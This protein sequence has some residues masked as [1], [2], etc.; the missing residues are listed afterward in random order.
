MAYGLRYKFAFESQSGVDYEIQILQDGYSGSVTQR[1]LGRA[2]VLRRDLNDCISG[3]SLEIA[4]EC[5]VDGEFAALYTSDAF[6]YKAVLYRS[7]S[8]I[9]TGFVSPELYSEP[10]IA[11]PYDVSITA[12]DGLGELRNVTFEGGGLK[13]LRAHLAALLAGTGLT[14]AIYLASGLTVTAPTAVAANDLL[15]RVSVDLDHMAGES[16]YD[17]LQALLASLHARI[18]QSRDKWLVYRDTDLEDDGGVTVYNSAGTALKYEVASFGS[19][20][21]HDWWP[22]GSM[23]SQVVPACKELSVMSEHDYVQVIPNGEITSDSDWTKVNATYIDDGYYRLTAG[24]VGQI[25]QTVVLTTATDESVSGTVT[26]TRVPLS[27][28]GKLGL[29]ILASAYGSGETEAQLYVSVQATFTNGTTAYLTRAGSGFFWSGTAGAWMDPFPI[30]L[31]Q[32]TYGEDVGTEV[33][34]DIP[35]YTE[36]RTNGTVASLQIT[37]G[38]GNTA[39]SYA[40]AIYAVVAETTPQSRGT[41]CKVVIDN[42]AR[43]EASETEVVLSPMV[44]NSRESL[45]RLRYGLPIVSGGPATTFATGKL[46]ASDYLSVIARDY[47]LSC[48]LPRLRTTG[49]LQV[50]AST[51]GIPVALKDSRGLLYFPDTVSWDL[52]L[53]EMTVDMTSLPAAQITVES[54]VMTSV[55]D[56]AS[57]SAFSPDYSG[58]GSG[59]SSAGA[60]EALESQV[61]AL[62]QGFET[63]EETV[64]VL[65]G[66][67]GTLDG[68][69][70]TN[71]NSISSLSTTI[72]GVSLSVDELTENYTAL[73][74]VVSTKLDKSIW[75]SIFEIKTTSRGVKYVSVKGGLAANWLSY[76]E[77]DG[78]SSGGGQSYAQ[79]NW[80]YIQ[81]M[82]ADVS[83]DLASAYAVKQAYDQLAAMSTNVSFSQ[84][85]TGGT[86]IGVI[87]IDDVAQNIYAPT[88]PTSLKNPYALT[89]GSKTYDGSA[90]RTVLASDLGALTAHQSIYTLTFAAGAFSA[91]SFVANSAAKTIKVPTHT[92]H[93]TNNSGYITAD[94]IPTTIDWGNVTGKPTFAAVATSGSY[95]DLSNKPTIPTIPS[96][97]AWSAITS[98]PT[99]IAG[100]GITDA[101]TKGNIG[102]YAIPII[103]G[104]P[105]V[106]QYGWPN[107]EYYHDSNLWGRIGF[108][109]VGVAAVHD[110]TTW[111]TLI[112]SGNIGSQSVASA[113]SASQLATARTIWGQSFDGTG[114]VSGD[115]TLVNASIIGASNRKALH[116]S[117]TDLYI[118]SGYTA[119]GDRAFIYGNVIRIYTGAIQ[120][121]MFINASGG[122]TIGSSDKIG[123]SNTRLW[124][125]GHSRFASDAFLSNWAYLR[126]Y[127]T[128]GTEHTVIGVNN[129]DVLYINDG[130]TVPTVIQGGHVGIGTTSPMQKLDVNG[131]I[132]IPN[133][134]ALMSRTAG[135][136]AIN[137]LYVGNDDIIKL[138]NASLP[139]RIQ[140]ATTITGTATFSSTLD[141]TGVIHSSA[142]IWTDGWLSF[143]D[144]SSTSDARFKKD[145]EAISSR[146]ALRIIK[147]LKPCSWTWNELSK[148]QGRGLGF[149]AQEMQGI[150]PEAIR[151]IGD[152]KHL[153][154]NYQMLHAL[155]VAS[156]QKHDD[157]ITR[158]RRRVETLEKELY[159][160]RRTS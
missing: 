110:T 156:I 127:L 48:A 44:A 151:E 66:T 142:G 115:I 70:T 2:P 57:G 101:I 97:Y 50:P 106:I 47:G 6:E 95:N 61:T 77:I 9:W 51:P 154:V 46:E 138:G 105:Q 145:I 74:G 62:Q 39:D 64:G 19:M 13:T 104:F 78:S 79:R 128:D 4:A 54:D 5:L 29:R 117:G 3:S 86:L 36:G 157:E 83:G 108:S 116:T 125:D 136:T 18:V 33:A 84:S 139:V 159:Q 71:A 75:D 82:T 34:I 24:A 45:Y 132:I 12:T 94:D 67:V 38:N 134:S 130:T 53:D 40:R 63:L 73:S 72:D 93:L 146:D 14:R 16:S 144:L 111:R 90:A 137:V 112:H 103:D 60:L 8:V 107:I 35:I 43:E 149:I 131:N 133:H 148:T 129:K 28:Q 158:L 147:A 10:D 113:T 141:A 68:R 31:P 21:T 37:V 123:T 88:I 91:G 122:V 25:Y 135:G 92:S 49:V 150:L 30:G 87:T 55:Y 52:L 56:T 120:Q 140:G 98:T 7:G 80:A 160:L 81:G 22:V 126:T 11:P 102:A 155:E 23:S 76:T 124:V 42:D 26:Q 15:D 152:D 121:A 1:A 17:V 69:I 143:S 32:Q 20:R 114:D 100:Y 119:S 99:T 59:G 96:T 27:P 58:G 109:G 153:A 85:Q 118:G 89:F 65:D 41:L